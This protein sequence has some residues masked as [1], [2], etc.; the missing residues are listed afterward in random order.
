MLQ[1]ELLGTMPYHD[2]ISEFRAYLTE[3]KMY[4]TAR[5]AR[6]TELGMTTWEEVAYSMGAVN[7]PTSLEQLEEVLKAVEGDW[8]KQAEKKNEQG[9]VE[10]QLKEGVN[11]DKENKVPA[12]Y[13]PVMVLPKTPC[14]EI[15]RWAIIVNHCK[16]VTLNAEEAR[17]QKGMDGKVPQITI[18]EREDRR[19]EMRKQFQ[20]TNPSLFRGEMCPGRKCEDLFYQFLFE[21][22]IML[23]SEEPS[24]GTSMKS[25]AKTQ[26]NLFQEG[27]HEQ[28][29]KMQPIQGH[30]MGTNV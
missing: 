9:I 25:K 23:S 13:E 6:L 18:H 14:R 16:Q 28:Q 2:S 20:A 21:N 12:D 11:P 17:Y 7:L 8:T 22:R 5:W 30:V 15:N 27:V 29:C 24:I 19:D 1:P 26:C 10:T 3:K 4:T